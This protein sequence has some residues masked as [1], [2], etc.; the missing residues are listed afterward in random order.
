MRLKTIGPVLFLALLL[1]V[2]SLYPQKVIEMTASSE[3]PVNSAERAFDNN[4]QTRWESEWKEDQWIQA[5]FEKRTDLYGMAIR[6]ETAAAFRYEVWT[7]LDN[8]D[9]DKQA[10]VTNIIEGAENWIKFPR[11]TSARFIRVRCLERLTEWGFSIW[12]IRFFLKPFKAP[13]RLEQ[14]LVK[15]GRFFRIKKEQGRYWFESPERSRFISR[16]VNVALPADNAA[17]PDAKSYNV[18]K[19]YSSRQEWAK[20]TLDRLKSWNFNTIGAWSDQETWKRDTAFTV[21]FYFPVPGVHRLCDVF[22]P[23]FEASAERMAKMKCR[24]YKDSKY[25][26]GYFLD[27]ELPWWGDYAWYTDH[28]SLLIDEY[29]IL[30]DDAPGKK[31]VVEFFRKRY[32]DIKKFNA[33]WGTAFGNFQDIAKA[34]S[35][36]A[37]SRPTWKDRNDFAGLVAERYFSVL[38]GTLR[39]YD[40]NHLILGA[41]FSGSP[42]DAVVEACGRHCDVVSVNYYCKSMRVNRALFDNIYFLAKKPVLITEFSYRAMENASGLENTLGADVTVARQE[43]RAAGYQKYIEQVMALPYIVGFHWFQY[44]DQSPQGRS[45]DGENSNY[46]IVDIYDRE[47]KA[48]VESMKSANQKADRIHSACATNYPA[49]YTPLYAIRVDDSGKKRAPGLA[50]LNLSGLKAEDIAV[51]GDEQTGGFVEISADKAGAPVRAEFESGGGWGCGFTFLP[52]TKPKNKDGTS[53]LR[54]FEGIKLTLSAPDKLVFNVFLNESGADA[55]GKALYT[56]FGQSDGESFTSEPLTGKGKFIEY[57]LNFRD[58]LLRFSWGNQDG[59]RRMD[60]EAM[61][62][63]DIYIPGLSGTGAIRIKSITLF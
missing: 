56:A 45:F 63:L 30:P 46:G 29:M 28:P 48:L 27:N 31:K 20:K 40:P 15:G 14:G 23:D 59:N 10:V 22:D 16:G 12:E 38:A 60:L 13:D 6:W 41:R 7:S 42:P 8:R 39:K 24:M 37:V 61:K 25:L 36:D 3:K 53:D 34:A 52:D 19:K 18:E 35:L 5:E 57:R 49:G 54:G 51:W 62:S 55:P 9:W 17:L 47:Y 44:F 2:L 43:D 32:K 21:M 58:F 1:P 11:K 4:S 26:L 33:V 50:F